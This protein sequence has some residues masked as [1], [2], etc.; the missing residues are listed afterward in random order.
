M[1]SK[2]NTGL[3]AFIPVCVSVVAAQATTA[4]TSFCEGQQHLDLGEKV[5]P[6]SSKLFL[7]EYFIREAKIARSQLVPLCWL[8]MHHEIF[9]H[10]EQV[11]IKQPSGW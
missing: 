5:N 7:S 4:L 3:Q 10:Q 9:S 1:E 6:F 8:E 11:Y 2:L